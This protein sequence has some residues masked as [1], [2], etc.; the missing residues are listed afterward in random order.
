MDRNQAYGFQMYIQLKNK[1][2][3]STDKLFLLLENIEKEGSI[4]KAASEMKLSYRYS[5]G[6][7]KDTEEL[8]GTKLL[9]RKVGGS[10]G[11]GATLTKEGRELLDHYQTIRYSLDS[12][13]TALVQSKVE[14]E[15]KEQGAG[16]GISFKYLLMASTMEPIDT[17]LMDLLEK[18]YFMKTGI[19]VRHI[20]VGSGKALQIAKSGGVDLVLAHSPKEEEDFMAKGF[21]GFRKAIM[22]NRYYLVGPESDPAELKNIKEDA[23]IDEFFRQMG[24][25]KAVFIS[26]GDNSGT[27]EKE[28]ELWSEAKISTEERNT[29]IAGSISGNSECMDFALEKSAYTLVD[30][31]SYQLY[32]RKENLKVFAGNK[33]GLH[34][35]LDNVFS[36]VAVRRFPAEEA[37]FEEAVRF[38]N[39]LSGNEGSEIIENYPDEEGQEPYFHL[40]K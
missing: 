23:G 14:E 8:L 7:I 36:L 37:R 30:S 4:S 12:Q 11:G 28:L 18:E 22:A 2:Q 9:Y 1:K 24:E 6:L 33:R 34:P 40:M 3:I 27:H 26:R 29:M 16:E 5:W 38:I 21:G 19:L 31:T 32:N 20:S 15:D 25:T 13:L 39:W 10:E 17:G 35:K